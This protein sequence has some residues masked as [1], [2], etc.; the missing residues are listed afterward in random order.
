MPALTHSGP[1]QN[2]L[3]RVSYSQQLRCRSFINHNYY[4]NNTWTE[5][6]GLVSIGVLAA[7][8]GGTEI[9]AEFVGGMQD[10]R[11]AVQTLSWTVGTAAQFGGPAAVDHANN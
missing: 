7:G 3:P 10:G 6:R 11:F 1:A 9:W 2:P 5:S 8:P 4:C